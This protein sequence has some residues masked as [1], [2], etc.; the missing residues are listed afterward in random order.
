MVSDPCVGVRPATVGP[1]VEGI[2]M[3]LGTENTSC[4]HDYTAE[5]SIVP[6]V[7][8]KTTEDEEQIL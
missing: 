4:G 8:T 5:K 6:G 7:D 3:T 2:I 1:T